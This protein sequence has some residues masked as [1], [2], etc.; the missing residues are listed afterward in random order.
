MDEHSPLP[1]M[2]YNMP[3]AD[4]VPRREF[5]GVFAVAV[6]LGSLLFGVLILRLTARPMAGTLTLRSPVAMPAP[7]PAPVAVVDPNQLVAEARTR[8]N[9]AR[10][11]SL[12]VNKLGPSQVVYDEDPVAARRLLG[13]G[14]CNQ[15]ASRREMSQPFFSAFEPPV[16]QTDGFWRENANDEPE[17]LLFAHQLTSPNGNQRLVLLDMQVK[18]D[19]T[20]L[21]GEEY[22][23]AINRQLKYRICEP[24]LL[25][26]SPSTVRYGQSLKIVQDGERNVIPIKWVDGTLRSARPQEYNLRFFAG[27]ADPNDA[28]H[29]TVDY[30]VGGIKSTIDGWLTDDDFLRIIPRGGKV[31][32]GI[33][34]IEAVK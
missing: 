14:V 15:Q 16:Y 33:W 17:A 31:E 21:A 13:K 27:Q 8:S 12:L 18:L 6:V 24:K 28:S 3:R 4:Q 26:T 34:Q 2:D 20:K 7:A 10:L 11:N 1:V 22:K 23:V 25:G 32:R 29:F 9:E 5:I 19:G 30:E